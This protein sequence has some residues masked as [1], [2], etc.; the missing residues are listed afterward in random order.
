M[1]AVPSHVEIVQHLY[2]AFARGDLPAV[3]ALLSPDVVW[4]EPAN[5]HN[6]AAG[7]R[8]GHGGF[9]E[10]ARIGRESEEILSLEPR[11]F[12]TNEKMVGVLGYMRCRARSTGRGYASDFVHVIEFRDG[13]IVRFQEFFDT[14]A[15]AE[16]FRT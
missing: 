16:A 12:L 9:L 14:W 1:T 3:L 7:T 8:R 10:W 2:T 5:P 11:E 4:T 13:R 15:A 6:P